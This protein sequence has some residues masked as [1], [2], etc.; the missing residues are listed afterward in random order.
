MKIIEARAELSREL[1]GAEIMRR[2]KTAD[3]RWLELDGHGGY[4][5]NNRGA[6]GIVASIGRRGDH[7]AIGAR[8]SRML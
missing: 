2:L 8:G 1:D 7:A 4:D 3:G 5:E 6:G